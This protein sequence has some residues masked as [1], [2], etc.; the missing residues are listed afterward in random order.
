M[1]T[2]QAGP[3]QGPPPTV[4][5]LDPTERQGVTGP[6]DVVGSVVSQ[7]LLGWNLEHRR[8]GETI[9]TRFASGETEAQGA[10][11]GQ[12]DPTLL[13]N[14]LYELRLRATDNAGRSAAASV[15]VVVKENQKVGHFSVS[16]V[17]LEV[18][19]AGL[20]LRVTRTYDN[21]DKGQGA[22]T[23]RRQCRQ[24]KEQIRHSEPKSCSGQTSH[25]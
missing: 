10:T 20:P 21:R 6:I 8:V 3:T 24:H 23:L 18:P 14:G 19:L 22:P 16:F 4:A 13:L 25:F 9:W 1:V 7:S 15:H 17:D 5:I 12:L 11:L 2:V